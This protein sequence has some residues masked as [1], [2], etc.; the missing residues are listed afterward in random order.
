MESGSLLQRYRRDRKKLLAFLLSS[1]FVRELR[2]P[3]GPVTDFSAVDLDS[4]SAS[5]VLECIKSGNLASLCVRDEC[6]LL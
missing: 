1:R 5:Y 2:T 6:E 4:L 3:A